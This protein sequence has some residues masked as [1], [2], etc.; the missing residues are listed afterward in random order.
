M[1]RDFHRPWQGALTPPWD[2][3]SE[4]MQHLFSTSLDTLAADAGAQ[5]FVVPYER[6]RLT[7][8]LACEPERMLRLAHDV[9][10][11]LVERQRLRHHPLGLA[12]HHDRANVASIV[13]LASEL[14]TFSRRPAMALA[15]VARK[16]GYNGTRKDAVGF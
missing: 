2:P 11:L 8:L 7:L 6:P 3:E 13:V 14:E 5:G 10:A 9:I 1:P 15:A 12:L 4:P 16:R